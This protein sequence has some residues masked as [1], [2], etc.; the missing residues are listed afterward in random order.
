[1]IPLYDAL[2]RYFRPHSRPIVENTVKDK[3]FLKTVQAGDV[4]IVD[5]GFSQKRV[6]VR[7]VIG[8]LIEI[9]LLEPSKELPEIQ[10]MWGM[11]E[12]DDKPF[13]NF[14]SITTGGVVDFLLGFD[15]HKPGPDHPYEFMWCEIIG[16]E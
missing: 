16:K 11:A 3:A 12:D 9:T 2:L 6:L 4:L 13:C 8:N 14:F 7:R 5:H 1:M 10:V 15:G